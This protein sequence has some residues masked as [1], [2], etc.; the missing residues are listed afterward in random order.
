MSVEFVAD[1]RSEYYRNNDIVES[2]RVS[3]AL[4]QSEPSSSVCEGSSLVVAS[5]ASKESSLSASSAGPCPSD[6]RISASVGA[7]SPK[8]LPSSPI[9]R[10]NLPRLPRPRAVP[11]RPVRRREAGLR[12]VF[13]H[14]AGPAGPRTAVAEYARDS[15]HGVATPIETEDRGTGDDDCGD[16]IDGPVKLFLLGSSMGATIALSVARRM[17]GAVAGVVLLAPMLRLPV[18]SPARYA[19][20]ALS[21]VVPDWEIIPSSSTDASKQYRDPAKREECDNHSSNASGGKIMVRSASTCVELANG[22]QDEFD[23]VS[24]PFLVIVADEDVIVDN[25]GSYDLLD[26]APSEDKT[27]RN[28]PALHGLLCEPSPLVEEIEGAMVEWIDAR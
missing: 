3:V 5:S 14:R 16:P 20:R 17:N 15:H 22:V 26:R 12:G 4:S 13:G 28:F 10:G 24:C 23:S 8:I 1:V 11:N 7:I 21:L 25:R 19:L 2:R 9:H 6:P 27:M 18:G